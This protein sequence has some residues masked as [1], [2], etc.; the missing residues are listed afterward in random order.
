MAA[1]GA[2]ALDPATRF[3]LS[4]RPMDPITRLQERAAHLERAVEELSAIV[5]RQDRE[6]TQLARRVALLIEREAD[7]RAEGDVPIDRPPHW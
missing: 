4:L 6:L 5:A 2:G 1:N 7:R 3:V